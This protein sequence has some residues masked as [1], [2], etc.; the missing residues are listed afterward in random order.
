M[1]SR[2]SWVGLATASR[3]SSLACSTARTALASSSVRTGERG[4]AVGTGD[5]CGVSVGAAT[6]GTP[7]A[8]GGV[9][10][11]TAVAWAATTVR[12]GAGVAVGCG[13]LETAGGSVG[14]AAATDVPPEAPE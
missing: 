8:G 4:V 10:G 6:V 1:A 11:V 5:T 7:V 14:E 13:V 12:E 9:V 2:F 3:S